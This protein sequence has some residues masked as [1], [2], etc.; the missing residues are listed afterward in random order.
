MT[1]CLFISSIEASNADIVFITSSSE[2]ADEV[3]EK[4]GIISIPCIKKLTSEVLF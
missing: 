2:C 1:L 4:E 3:M